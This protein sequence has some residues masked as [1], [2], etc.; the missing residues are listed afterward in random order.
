[1]FCEHCGDLDGQDTG[2]DHDERNCPW[3]A[4][5]TW[6]ADGLEAV[7]R[8]TAD[9]N[10]R[11]TA[12]LDLLSAHGIWLARLAERTYLFIG[13]EDTGTVYDLDWPAIADAVNE[14]AFPGSGSELRILGLAAS[15]ASDASVRLGDAVTGLDTTNLRLF[16]DAIATANGRPRA[17]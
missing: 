2:A 8:Q 10:L 17:A 11:M 14:L 15:L 1:M 13:D 6:T 16:L 12:A 7:L 3:Y 5:E 4:A 9:G